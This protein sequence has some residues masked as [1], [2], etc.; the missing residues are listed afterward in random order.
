[1][2]RIHR[3]SDYLLRFFSSAPV[4]ARHPKSPWL[5]GLP[6]IC[7]ILAACS[8][9]QESS[10][11]KGIEALRRAEPYLQ[12][13]EMKQA[14]ELASE[15]AKVAADSPMVLQRA[16]EILFLSGHSKE[17]LPL[18]ARV[19]ELVPED[20]PQ[21]WQRGIALSSCGQF[22]EGANQFETHHQVNPDDVENSAWYFLCIAKTQGIAAARQTVIPS[23]GDG[24]QPMMAVLEMLQQKIPPEQVLEAAQ[25][26]TFAGPERKRAQFYAALYVG[27]YY[28]ALGDEPQAIKHLKL[29]L[30]YGDSGYMVE[31]ARVYLA[32]RFPG[33]ESAQPAEK[34]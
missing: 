13:R 2:S 4:S 10:E 24:R 34:K 25:A 18:F 33:A 17:S 7:M 20:A 3:A 11:A 23:R 27:L 14:A 19:V 32:D 8:Q 26:N 6:V 30:S 29:S 15:A 9:A 16:A 28:D 31:S 5:L 1:M 12:R 21:N 22:A